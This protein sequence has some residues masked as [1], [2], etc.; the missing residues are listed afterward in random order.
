[1]K[2]MD[3]IK[4][5]EN[6]KLYYDMMI[7]QLNSGDMSLYNE[8]F[9]NDYKS[10]LVMPYEFLTDPFYLSDYGNQ[11][12]P[13]LQQDFVK[14]FTSFDNIVEV[15]L[16]GGIRWGKNYFA[17]A[18]IA[19]MIYE[20][21]MLKDPQKYYN[22]ATSSKLYIVNF[23]ISA[24]HAQNEFFDELKTVIDSSMFFSKY[25]INKHLQSEIHFSLGG[26]EINRGNLILLSGNS[27]ELSGI[28]KSIIAGIMDEANFM[29]DVKNS[30]RSRG[31]GKDSNHYSAAWSL[32]N[33]V[34]RRIKLQFVKSNGVIPA[35]FFII[36]SQK[37]E[38]D[39][40]NTK[41]DMA[42]TNK[43][44]SVFILRYNNWHT[45]PKY[46]GMK[47][48]KVGIN[49]KNRKSRILSDSELGAEFE[50]VIDV[51]YILKQEFID[52]F[53]GA[54][55]DYAGEK[56]FGKGKFINKAKIPHIFSRNIVPFIDKNVININDENLVFNNHYKL[57]I[58][59]NHVAHVDL[60]E[61]GDSV[62]IALSYNDAPI[63]I[64]EHH[65]GHLIK[66]IRPV[67]ITDFL[68]TITPPE[69][70]QIDFDKIYELF[71]KLTN[72]GIQI[73][74]ITFDK[75]QSTYLMQ[76]LSKYGF[77]CWLLSVDRTP[78]AYID[79]RYTIN[80]GRYY[81]V[82]SEV[83]EFELEDIEK[84]E[85]GK[86][87][88][89][90]DGCFSG[91]TK[92]KLLNGK[93]LA[94]EEIYKNNMKEFWVYSSTPKGDIRPALASNCH[95][96]KYVDEIAEITLDTG[97]TIQCT[98]D[99]LFMLRNGEYKMAKNL[100]NE[101]SLM[102]LYTRYEGKY[103]LKGYERVFNNNMQRWEM[104]HAM[105][106][107]ALNFGVVDKKNE[108]IH[109]YD[110]DPLNNTPENLK[111]MTRKE[112]GEIHKYLSE[113]A[114]KPDVIKRRIESFKKNYWNSPERQ[115][116]KSDS[117]KKAY[118]GS[119]QKAYRNFSKE[120]K[121]EITNKRL[122]TNKNFSKEKKQ[123]ITN[124]RIETNRKN[125]TDKVWGVNISKYN[126]SISA[127]IRSQKIAKKLNEVYWKS[128]FGKNLR[129]K[130]SQTQLVSAR[131]EMIYQR[132][133]EAINNLGGLIY[134]IINVQQATKLCGGG[135]KQWIRRFKLFDINL[136]ENL[137]RLE[138]DLKNNI[139]KLCDVGISS[140]GIFKRYKEQILNFNH[141]IKSVTIKKLDKSIPVYDI[142]VP[143]Y[144]NFALSCG[145]FVHNSKDLSDCSAATVFNCSKKFLQNNHYSGV[146]IIQDNKDIISEM[147]K[148]NNHFDSEFST[149]IKDIW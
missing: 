88:H 126:K 83:L 15:I 16:A 9:A 14:L 78:D 122:E 141:K 148:I 32:Y 34:L 19:R 10:A 39:F 137:I 22:M 138:N 44:K 37:H 86:I 91:D 28:G 85:T 99:H 45:N 84:T 27:S 140:Y 12:Y 49:D 105:V 23:S 130:L 89:P 114:R 3:D 146:N 50:K 90:S 21:L 70:E 109:H 56:F 60:A 143:E 139:I 120:K 96:T 73:S 121:Q 104:T 93:H 144:E 51:P 41:I 63:E 5:S 18:A 61:S 48:F 87:D 2:I 125:G 80:Q 129:K 115:K 54:M 65:D 67:I 31:H 92:I 79:L 136:K 108:V 8:I 117:A 127:S 128:E 52:D 38:K 131:K 25:R 81:S 116:Q 17:R 119:M 76:R 30:K 100:C 145:I 4:L 58:N 43:D 24:T 103:W 112:H 11:L 74:D 111:K 113:L 95:I 123:E 134:Y 69:H 40:V 101:D 66:N 82:Y 55:C 57:Y 94:F 72:I 35:K 102:P 64:E 7:E 36:S 124:K 97:E 147:N 6:E 53:Q 135:R 29:S 26:G 132:D 46:Q 59:K 47:K 42:E 75:F 1:M 77:N 33:A 68:L 62:G 110:I 107:R 118:N 98:P 133:S 149:N 13:V 20:V 71:I 106:S 142:S